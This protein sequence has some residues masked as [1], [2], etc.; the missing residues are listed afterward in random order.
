MIS[1]IM[2]IKEY[3]QDE[4]I[5]IIKTNNT[6]LSN[7]IIKEIIQ[8]SKNLRIAINIANLLETIPQNNQKQV[9]EDTLSKLNLSNIILNEEKKLILEILKENKRLKGGELYEL[10]CDKTNYPKCERAFRKYTQSLFNEGLIS[11]IGQKK[12]RIYEIV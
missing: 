10:Y 4:K 6:N 7:E 9:L 8:K 3:K 5:E 1:S 2:E 12:G 11:S